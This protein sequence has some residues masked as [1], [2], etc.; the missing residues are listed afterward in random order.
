[1]A[2][3]TDSKA[4]KFAVRMR[5]IPRKVVRCDVYGT[6]AVAVDER[7]ARN[8]LRKVVP[9]ATSSEVYVALMIMQERLDDEGRI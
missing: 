3:D 7:H 1:M 6:V 5:K 9:T 8:I 4:A 2:Q